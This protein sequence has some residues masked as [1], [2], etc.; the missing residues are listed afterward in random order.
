APD[1]T[2]GSLL[3]LRFM[4]PSTRFPFPKLELPR[5]PANTDIAGPTILSLQQLGERALNDFGVRLGF[6]H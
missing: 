1:L 6:I 4:P 3:E 5:R 2:I